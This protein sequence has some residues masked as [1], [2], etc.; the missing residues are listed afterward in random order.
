MILLAAAFAFAACDDK[1]GKSLSMLHTD[2]E[3]IL[4]AEGETV[5]LRGTN[6]GGWLVQESWM[7]PTYQ[8][9]TLETNMT[10]YARFGEEAAEELIDVYE[11][12]WITEADFA[13]VK[14]LGLNTVRIPFTYMNI[15]RYLSAEANADGTYDVEL[16]HP[17]EFTLRDDAFARLDRALELCEKYGLY[18]ILDLHGAVGSQNGKDHSGDTRLTDLYED[19]ELGEAYRA[20]TAE[21][22]GL[23]AEHFAGD[24]YV[25]GYDLLN[26][27]EG[28]SGEEQWDYYDVLYDA[29]REKDGDHIIFIEAVWD[30]RALPSP[31]SYEWTNVVYEY[32]HYNWEGQYEMPNAQFYAQKQYFG[33]RPGVPAL[34]GEFNAWGDARFGEGSTQTDLEANEGVLEFYN[35]EGWHWT[36]WT[37][38]VTG[39][40]SPSNWGLY[41]SAENAAKADPAKDSYENILA[42]WS[43]CGTEESFALYED[44]SGIV[45]AAAAAPFG[46]GEPEGGYAILS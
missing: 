38:K 14:R 34:V 21:L 5:A 36:T 7:C 19:S 4:N 35:G 28:A 9:D 24:P 16:L 39:N 10:L 20:K 22:W 2:G 30:A 23:V 17:D 25:A 29:V 45:S 3:S 31:S 32:H 11:D 40:G 1:D 18:A 33:A 37:Y 8:T 15:Y 26:E 12:N 41:N 13:N 43:S 44:F 6:F 27:P 42:V 46:E